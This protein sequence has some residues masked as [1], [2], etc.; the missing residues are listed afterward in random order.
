MALQLA[1][2]TLKSEWLPSEL[3][4][5]FDARQIAIDVE[6]YDPNLKKSDQDGQQAMATLSAAIAVDSV[7]IHHTPRARR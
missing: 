4:D 6:T 5:I 7:R 2:D 3:P 1:F